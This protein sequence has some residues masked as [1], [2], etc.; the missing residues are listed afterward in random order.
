MRKLALALCIFSS[1]AFAAN[2]LSGLT[3][4]LNIGGK[5]VEWNFSVDLNQGVYTA[6]VDD[7][8]VRRQQQVTIERVYGASIDPKPEG[9]K[10]LVNLSPME[11]FL[12]FRF[13]DNKAYLMPMSGSNP[14]YAGNCVDA[15]FRGL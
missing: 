2:G 9:A 14:R 8:P 6:F 10:F 3:C 12:Y 4:Q 15:K 13:S 11:T 5:Q 7:K 1:P